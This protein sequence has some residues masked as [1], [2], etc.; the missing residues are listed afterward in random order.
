MTNSEIIAKLKSDNAQSIMLQFSDLHGIAK[1]FTIPVSKA[2]DALASGIWFDGSSIVGF[3]RIAESDM[4]LKPDISTYGILEWLTNSEGK[5]ARFICDVHTPEDEPFAG[6]PR[7]VL[8]KV[9]EKAR[10]MGY[11]Y[12]TGVELEFFLF[13]TENGAIKCESAGNGYYFN[14]DTARISEIKKEILKALSALHIDVEV[15]H[16]EVAANQ[17][18]IDFKYADAVKTADNAMTFKFAVKS[19]AA[20]HGM[21]ATFM[22]KPIFGVNGSGMHT[23]QSFSKISDDTNAFYDARDPYHLSEIAKQFIAGLLK[24]AKEYSAVIAPTVNSYKRLTPGFEAPVYVCWASRNR[25]AL[26]RIPK[27]FKD[28]SHVATRAELRCPDPASN[29][30]L[31]FAVMLS[32][33]LRGIENAYTLPA[34]SEEDVFELDDDKLTQKNIDKLPGTLLE[35]LSYYYK[36]DLVKEALGDH[37]YKEYYR[38]KYAEWDEFRRAVTDWE[39]KKYLEVL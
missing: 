31:A 6:D 25:S 16:S 9:M 27:T 35:A 38:A 10:R 30:Y 1:S 4:Y 29:P 12:K 2:D 32:S 11:V 14:A 34:P 21:H 15:S 23:H 18:E 5:T 33:G 22:P 13:E 28:K 8:K 17:H 24:H 26:V 3:T 39:I 19:I 7:Y 20:K 36:S 37:L